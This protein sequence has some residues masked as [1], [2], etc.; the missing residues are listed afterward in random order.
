MVLS[1]LSALA[2]RA[3]AVRARLDR[4]P[5]PR[6]MREHLLTA[7]I[8]RDDPE[9]EAH[10]TKRMPAALEEQLSGRDPV[11]VRLFH[12][13]LAL[14]R[15]PRLARALEALWD[16]V[17]AAGVAPALA[18]GAPTPAALL[19]ARPTLAALF[20][21]CYWGRLMPLLYAYP[22]DLAEMES[23]VAAGASAAE[24]VDAHLVG[25]LV[26]ELSH[27]LPADPDRV[28]APAHLHEAV[29]GW[30]GTRVWPA[31]SWPGPGDGDALPG[32]PWLVY[33]GAWLA[34]IVGDDALIRAQA[35]VASLDD[36]LGPACAVALRALA[37]Q[38][39]LARWGYALLGDAFAP[40]PWLKLLDLH[41]DPVRAA[42]FAREHVEPLL[43][44]APAEAASAPRLA[45]TLEAMPW[46][47]LPA[48][49]ESPMPAD[50]TLLAD[51]LAAQC[52]RAVR[53]GNTMRARVEPATVTLELAACLATRDG[54]RDALRAPLA[55][56]IPP[57][58]CALASRQEPLQLATVADARAA[59][60][61][62]ISLANPPAR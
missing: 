54:P 53:V 8:L 48:W 12:G 49:H 30:L 35:G 37:W 51:A 9:L 10:Y 15:M 60:R 24:L 56:P 61:R 62:I 4:V 5:M 58:V 29:A 23:A 17:A 44:L 34:R 41:R 55:F 31:Q 28:P 42:D 57:S 47:T 1:A 50:E 13:P 46:S 33:L 20:G 7:L 19:T 6:S 27:L 36:L 39:Q 21:E 2:D 26:H 32:A 40:A 3:L 11:R 59:A 18:L 16:R 45:A 22:G 38:D 25:P 43:A 52:V 14:G